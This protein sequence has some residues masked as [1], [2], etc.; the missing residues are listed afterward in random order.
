MQL[1]EYKLGDIG[2]V[3]TGKTPATSNNVNFE[4]GTIPFYTPEDVAKGFD[5]KSGNKRFITSLGFEEIKN[6]TIAGESVL[7]GC[8]GSDMGN[9]A[10]VNEICATNQQ[11]NS[12]TDFKEFVEPL[13]VYYLLSTMKPIFRQLAG[14]TTTPILAKS[15]FENITISLPRL[16]TQKRVCKIL[17]SF[18]SKIV[19]NRQINQNLEAL[20]RQLYDY[21]FVQFDFPDANG[22]PYK[23]SGGKMV[24]NPILK[25]EIP[26][27]WEVK[28][29]KEIESNIITGK[30]PSTSEEDNFGE[31]IPFVTIDD[32]RKYMY[33]YESERTLSEKGADSQS[34]KYLPKGSLS[35]SCI[36]TAGILG[37]IGTLAQTNQQINS[38]IFNKDYNRELIYFALKWHFSHATAKMGNI[39][40]NMSKDEFSRIPIVY[41]Q[42]DILMKYHNLVKDL[43]CKIDNGVCTILSLTK[44]RDELLPLL[45]NGQVNFDLSDD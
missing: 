20:A 23:S 10:Y 37:F 24:Y 12:I 16:E 15:V 22:K 34:S 29:I 31:N 38:I 13:Y 43:F 2:R 36:G 45:M 11:I 32:I 25:R 4:G 44:Q 6:N 27:G 26:E 8:I 40:P 21:W 19:L 28:A 1:K 18:D 39:L 30:T 14:S 17:S 9:V 3:V 42:I 7:V 41:P 35:C 33:I 5:I